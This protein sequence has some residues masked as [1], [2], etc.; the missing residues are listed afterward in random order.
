MPITQ[1]A[2]G[3]DGAAGWREIVVF[4]HPHQLA[5]QQVSNSSAFKNNFKNVCAA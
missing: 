2:A 1:G 4:K 3:A 5:K